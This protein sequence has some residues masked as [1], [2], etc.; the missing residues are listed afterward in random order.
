M[1]DT[2]RRLS[3]SRRVDGRIVG[4]ILVL[5]GAFA[6]VEGRRLYHLRETLVAGAVVGDDTFPII[7]G[8]A[9]LVLGVYLFIAAPPPAARVSLPS[10]PVRTQMLVGAGVLALYWV[11]VPWLGYTAATAIVSAA[12]FRGMGGYRWPVAILL[13]A[14]TTGALYV[15][16]R[17][18]LLQPL[19]TGLLGA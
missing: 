11:L 13:A 16:F 14:V 17:V 9:L 1:S 18:W 19:P 10:G 5:S 3:D 8:V 4:G 12:L 7:V 2:R 15:L 6:L